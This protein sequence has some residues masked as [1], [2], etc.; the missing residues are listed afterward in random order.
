M[1]VLADEAEHPDFFLS[2]LAMHKRELSSVRRE[3]RLALKGVPLAQSPRLSALE[4][5]MPQVAGRPEHQ[6][7]PVWRQLRIQ[8]AAGLPRIS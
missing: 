5:L 8:D 1:C 7:T 4:R 2:L 3:G 6:A